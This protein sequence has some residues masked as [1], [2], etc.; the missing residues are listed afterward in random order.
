[1]YILN[2][3]C[4]DPN[5]VVIEQSKDKWHIILEK[6]IFP[7]EII[8]LVKCI[9]WLLILAEGPLLGK[10]T[11]FLNAELLVIKQTQPFF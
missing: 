10:C 9:E 7:V 3:T 5:T 6:I 8:L 4:W 11:D 2:S 1:M